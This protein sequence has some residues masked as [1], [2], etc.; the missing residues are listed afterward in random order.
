LN[1]GNASILSLPV[2]ATVANVLFVNLFGV[3]AF[4]FKRQRSFSI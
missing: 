4:F 3:S 1:Y 2:A